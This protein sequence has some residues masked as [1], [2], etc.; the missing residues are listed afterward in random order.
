METYYPVLYLITSFAIAIV[1]AMVA[2][3]LRNSKSTLESHLTGVWVNESQTMRILLHQI[4]SIFQGE[5]V[6]IN[7]IKNNHQHMLGTKMI[8]ELELNKIVQGSTGIYID[9]QSG[10]ELPFRLWLHGRGKL[11][12]AVINKVNGKNRV[13]KEERWF[14]L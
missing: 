11:K 2:N 10:E 7:S 14:Q 3:S 6:W 9:P 5:V 4:D 1:S 8:K 12:L 13:V